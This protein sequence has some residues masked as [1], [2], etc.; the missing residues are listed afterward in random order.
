MVSVWSL[1]SSVDVLKFR[2]HVTALE[3]S[4]TFGCDGFEVFT[5]TSQLGNNGMVHLVHYSRILRRIKL[6]TE[7]SKIHV[8]VKICVINLSMKFYFNLNFCMIWDCCS[9][10]CKKNSQNK[11]FILNNFESILL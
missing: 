9:L 8:K 4:D 11:L 1:C 6:A 2:L 7:N 10:K 5:K 3:D